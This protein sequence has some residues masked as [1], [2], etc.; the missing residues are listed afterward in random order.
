MTAWSNEEAQAFLEA[1]RH[2][3]LFFGWFLLLARG[4]RRGE[5]CGLRWQDVDFAAKVLRVTETRIVVGGEVLSSVPKTAS[6]RRTLPL[7]DDLVAVLKAHRARQAVERLAAGPA[8]EDGGWLLANELGRPYN[9]QAIS[10]SF[11]R[12]TTVAGIRRIR[13]HDTRH[14]AASLMLAD[15]VPT[16]V[17]SEMLGHAGPTITLALYAHVIPG[18]AEEAGASLSAALLRGR[19]GSVDKVLTSRPADLSGEQLH[20]L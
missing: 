3:R 9:P 20:P 7:D 18:M 15:G 12:R 10:A 13:L 2:D 8:Y 6:G 19:E 17:V 14:T 11:V 1:T 5:L 16:K 4:L